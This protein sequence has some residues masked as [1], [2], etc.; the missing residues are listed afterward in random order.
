MGETMKF[1]VANND[2]ANSVAHWLKMLILHGCKK[3]DVAVD[4]GDFVF[5][6]LQNKR[7]PKDRR[8]YHMELQH[9]QLDRVLLED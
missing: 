9:K 3:I 7:V 4:T 8:V 6:Q 2:E 1:Q 5:H